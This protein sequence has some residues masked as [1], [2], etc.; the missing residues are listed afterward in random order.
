[1]N[2]IHSLAHYMTETGNMSYRVPYDKIYEDMSIKG[3]ERYVTI[4]NHP[5]SSPP[6]I[7][8]ILCLEKGLRLTLEWF[9]VIM[10]MFISITLKF[11]IALIQM[12][13]LIRRLAYIKNI[14]A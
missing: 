1:M 12:I 6:S 11:K 7:D 2:D 4:H 9:Y 13:Y 10:E 5:N 3:T 14:I 8:D